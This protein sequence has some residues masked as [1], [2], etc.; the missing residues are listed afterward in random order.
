MTDKRMRTLG[1]IDIALAR[2][3]AEREQHG[4]PGDAELISQLPGTWNVVAGPQF[5]FSNEQAN[6]FADL[7]VQRAPAPRLYLQR[8]L[9]GRWAT[10]RGGEVK[11]RHFRFC[12]THLCH[13]AAAPPLL[14]PSFF[15][16]PV[17]SAHPLLLSA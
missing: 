5:T 9:G 16:P 17:L 6:L 13:A 4:I 1:C 7:F 8:K 11:M 2:Q 10:D 3:M 14:V 15:H 12:M